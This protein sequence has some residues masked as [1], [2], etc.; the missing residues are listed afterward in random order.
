M[1]SKR[2][3]STSTPN[4]RAQVSQNPQNDDTYPIL[5]TK[6]EE[7]LACMKVD[8]SA[9]LYEGKYE[10]G[11]S[12]S[13]VNIEEPCALRDSMDCPSDA[14]RKWDENVPKNIATSEPSIDARFSKATRDGEEV[15]MERKK[16]EKFKEK[17]VMKPA[18]EKQVMA[19]RMREIH[20][21]MAERARER[22]RRRKQGRGFTKTTNT[23]SESEIKSA[24]ER[25]RFIE[26]LEKI[27]EQLREINLR[28]DKRMMTLSLN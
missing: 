1:D 9:L 12:K 17:I 25:A 22:L 10:I 15:R 7:K 2:K 16:N 20:R 27:T 3:G 19:L 14:C 4:V 5:D 26:H 24:I 13:F 23:P 18:M 8:N 28:L 21:Q 11:Q 6:A